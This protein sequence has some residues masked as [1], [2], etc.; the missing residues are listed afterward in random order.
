MTFLFASDSLADVK[1]QYGSD[2]RL[3]QEYWENVFDLDTLNVKNEK[4][5]RLKASL[6]GDWSFNK[7]LSAYLKISSEPKY[8]LSSFS[9]D[10]T[11]FQQ[12]EIFL[13]AFL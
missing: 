1:A 13:R 5:F 4:Y 11:H 10:N 2:F 6:W 9:Q 12:D 8:Y 7:N 3:R